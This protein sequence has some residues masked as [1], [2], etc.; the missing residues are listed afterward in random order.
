MKESLLHQF[1]EIGGNQIHYRRIDS[2]GPVFTLLHGFGAS[3]FSW[4]EVIEP[5]SLHGTVLAY[6]RLGFG[7]SSRPNVCDPLDQ[8]PYGNSA[9]IDLLFRFLDHQQVQETFLVGHSAGGLISLGATIR[10]PERVKALVLI[11]PAVMRHRFVPLWIQPFF[12]RSISRKLF[13]VLIPVPLAHKDKILDRAWYNPGKISPETREG[14]YEPF[15]QKGMKDALYWI[16]EA[17]NFNLSDAEIAFIRIPALV[18]CGAE[19]R[20]VPPAVG[21]RV[22]HL[23]GNAEYIKISECGHI[24]H[25]EKPEEFLAIFSK[26]ICKLKGEK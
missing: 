10:Q 14:Y 18:I 23:L 8:N 24:P 12:K 5:I 6:D 26:F 11:A 20:I 19:D 13:D 3:L 21:E 17:A 16:S 7:Y 15:T 9:Q 4:H 1:M 22:A 25:E 2:T